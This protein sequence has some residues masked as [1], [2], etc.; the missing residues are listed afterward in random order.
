MVIKFSTQKAPVFTPTPAAETKLLLHGDN[1]LDY[2][3]NENDITLVGGASVNESGNPF[4]FGGVM[5]FDGIDGY[6]YADDSDDWD[7]GSSAISISMF[8]QFN[9]LSGDQTI[10]GRVG[11]GNDKSFKIIKNT[12]NKIQFFW[13]QYSGSAWD[14]A[15]TATTSMTIDTIYHIAVSGQAGGTLRLYINGVL[16]H[17]SGTF[18]SIRNSASNLAIGGLSS[19]S[20]YMYG[21][22]SEIR[23]L[24]GTDNGYTGATIDIPESPYGIAVQQSPGTLVYSASLVSNHGSSISGYT[25]RIRIPASD[26]DD[27]SSTRIRLLLGASSD[28]LHFQCD[29]M[30]IGKR[31]SSGNDW[32]FDG[33]QVP[34]LL[35][36]SAAFQVPFNTSELTD[37]S[38]LSTDG[39]DDIIVSMYYAAKFNYR[40]NGIG[41]H[42]YIKLGD[43][44]ADTAPAGYG[45]AFPASLIAAIR[46]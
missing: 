42:L 12:S 19:L 2:S 9:T 32:D 6:A 13:S 37:F 18:V 5:S 20:D 34:V 21:S 25:Y 28:G 33:N 40:S 41:C 43:T 23:I 4:G 11:S 15:L 27:I 8:V 17:S 45:S 46:V 38:T 14:F 7:F 35:N 31:A 24:K 44:A 3:G 36:G 39:T 22:I 29:K 16:E 30:Y 26:I 1:L 10:L